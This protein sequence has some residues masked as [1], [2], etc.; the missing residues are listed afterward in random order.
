MYLKRVYPLSLRHDSQFGGLLYGPST[1][2]CFFHCTAQLSF[3]GNA[4]IGEQHE[5]F[6]AFP[7]TYF[8]GGVIY[9]NRNPAKK[10]SLIP[11][12]L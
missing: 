10:E 12:P 7:K 8:A 9:T 5:L 4:A 11:L 1:L 6:I 3:F 2:H